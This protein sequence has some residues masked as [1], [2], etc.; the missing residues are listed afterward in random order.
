MGQNIR[1][2]AGIAENYSTFNREERNLAT[3]LYYLFLQPSNLD[4]FFKLIG[5]KTE[6]V[7]EEFGI[8]FEY[9]YLRDLWSK[10]GDNNIKRELIR[11]FLPLTSPGQI[12]NK[13]IYEFNSYFGA[14]REPSRNYIQ[15]PGTWSLKRYAPNIKDNEDLLNICKFKWSFNAKPDIVIN[16]SRDTAV[17]I[18]AK[19]ESGEGFYPQKFDEVDIF[20][21]RGIKR[22]SQTELQKYF[23]EDLLGIKTDFVFLVKKGAPVSSSH[24]VITWKQLFHCL[25]LDGAPQF[26]LEMIDSAK[27]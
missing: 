21:Q 19:S 18:E 23:M 3:V 14:V 9:S 16:T 5:S 24:K 26:I 1:E 8:Y 13:S 22:V 15:S 10:L 6:I 4:R 25:D 2:F 27:T 7:Q 12:F 17:C 20:K 11:T